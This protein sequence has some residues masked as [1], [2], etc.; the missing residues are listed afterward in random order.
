MN[1][2]VWFTVFDRVPTRASFVTF[3]FF[4]LGEVWECWFWTRQI[5]RRVLSN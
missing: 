2:A 1:A 3:P 4:T 5:P